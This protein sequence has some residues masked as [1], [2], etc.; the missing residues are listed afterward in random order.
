M[1]APVKFD[2]E[3]YKAAIP[4]GKN[5]RI[6]RIAGGHHEIMEMQNGFDDR[7]FCS[8][9]THLIDRRCQ[10][11]KFRPVDD[12]PRRC[13]EFELAFDSTLAWLASIGETNKE[14]IA[15]TIY[16]CRDDPETLAY[17]L[18]RASETP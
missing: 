17:F 14:I 8:E 13:A 3:T 4:E 16:R 2:F 6:A 15:E 12:I 9:C 1:K 18:R 7:H 10:V 11:H 5:R